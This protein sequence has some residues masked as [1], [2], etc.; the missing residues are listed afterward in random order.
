[1]NE[2]SRQPADSERDTASGMEPAAGSRE[3]KKGNDRRQEGAGITN[4]PIE[5]E[6]REQDS[7]PPRGQAKDGSHA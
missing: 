2:Q 1:M 5:E 6:Q 3:T 7:L 4:R